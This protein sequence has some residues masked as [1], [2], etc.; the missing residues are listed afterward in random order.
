MVIGAL[1]GALNGLIITRGRIPDFI[2]TLGTL[3]IFQGIAL[4]ITGGL[5]VPS[6]I[7]R[8]GIEGVPA[9][10][11]DLDGAGDSGASPSRA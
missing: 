2:A 4:I 5:P 11:D 8:H 3:T 7:D 9:R 1:A 6:H 10:A